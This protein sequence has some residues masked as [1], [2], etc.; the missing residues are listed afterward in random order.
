MS[1]TDHA[2]SVWASDPLEALA[3]ADAL[4]ILTPWPMYREIAPAEIVQAMTGRTVLD[5]Y[6][7]L[8]AARAAAA[9]LDMFTLGRAPLRG[10]PA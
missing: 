4:M 10:G 7:V 3:G 9:G 1:V 6:G 5:P 8:D 2:N